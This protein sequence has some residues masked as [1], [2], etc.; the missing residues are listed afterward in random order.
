MMHM[1]R[2]LVGA[3]LAAGVLLAG[4]VSAQSTEEVNSPFLDALNARLRAAGAHYEIAYAELLLSRDTQSPHTLVANNRTHRLASQFVECDARRHPG[5]DITYL[6]DQ[7]DGTALS[8]QTVPGGAVVT[9]T[10][11]V[12]EAQLDASMAAWDDFRCQG[13]NV[14]KVADTGA[15]PDVVDGLLG[16]GSVGTTFA[17]ITHA[18][19][20]PAAFFD[21]IAPNGSAS[22]LGVTFTFVF[23]GP[24]GPTDIDGDHRADVAF[25]EI[26]YNRAFPWGT[27]GNESNIDIQSVATHEAGHAFGLGHFGKVTVDLATFEFHYSPKAIMNAVYVHEDRRILGTDIGSFCSIWARSP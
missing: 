15:D 26:Y 17:D 10:N 12:T 2:T 13:P 21:A 1:N 5:C 11:A 25:K 3:V 27:G 7:S 23:D 22:I 6:V 19:W 16:Q 4:P 24:S 8:W 9:L 20:L 18:G 14:V